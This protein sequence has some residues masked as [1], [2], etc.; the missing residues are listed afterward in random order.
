MVT[1]L[2]ILAAYFYVVRF[3]MSPV[4]PLV[5]AMVILGT[6]PESLNNVHPGAASGTLV[7]AAV[8]AAI[9]WWC[10]NELRREETVDEVVLRYDW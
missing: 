9:S 2:A 4:P 6:L 1:G 10:F 7:G 5:G 8:I 3:Q